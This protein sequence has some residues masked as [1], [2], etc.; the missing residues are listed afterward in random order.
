MHS[1]NPPTRRAFLGSALLSGAA[2][3]FAGPAMARPGAGDDF[4]FEIIRTD[5]EW[6]AMLSEEEYQIL[7]EGETEWPRSNPLW[8]DYRAGEFC[9]RGCD[10][11]LYSSDWRAEIDKG[12]VFFRHS[13]PNA[14]LTAIDTATD[15][16]MGAAP[17]RT[18]IE[19]HCRRCGSHLGH[20]LNVDA[21][22]VH[23]VNGTALTFVPVET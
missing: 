5:E 6:R 20:I 17:A 10:L 19:M 13:E 22:L 23:C 16:S 1:K 4:S 18:A 3:P 2:I 15:Y 7:R 14:V 21:Q 11:P 9:C 8:D 12:W